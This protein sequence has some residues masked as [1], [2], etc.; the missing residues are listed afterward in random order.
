MNSEGEIAEFIKNQKASIKDADNKPYRCIC[1]V[2]DVKKFIAYIE[3]LQAENQ[4]LKGEEPIPFAWWKEIPKTAQKV[5]ERII[6][7]NEQ[8]QAENERLKRQKGC[9][10]CI[11]LEADGEII[12]QHIDKEIEMDKQ[13]EQLQVEN[14]RKENEVIELLKELKNK[15]PYPE[16]VFIEPTAKQ[17]SRFHQIL[18][19]EGLTLDKFS[20]S[21]G[22]HLWN[23]IIDELIDELGGQGK[24]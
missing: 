22:R 24:D 8:L 3:Q 7:R 5:M 19:K 13:I 9:D 11:Y 15:N 2:D 10:K 1:C 4:Q 17:Y 12:N 6:E 23:V 14:K 20:G 16:T 21:I 18:Q